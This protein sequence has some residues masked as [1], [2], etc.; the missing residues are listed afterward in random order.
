MSILRRFKTSFIIAKKKFQI[1]SIDVD[2]A[3]FERKAAAT[4]WNA[5]LP[6][7]RIRVVFL[8]MTPQVWPSSEPV[9]CLASRDNRFH[10]KV[11]VVESKNPADALASLR[12]SR[13]TLIKSGVPFASG[14]NFSLEAY[15]PHI[16]FYPLPY[17]SLYPDEFNT[18][19]ANACGARIAYIPYGLE[20][21]GGAYNARYQFD[22]VMLRNAWRIFARSKSQQDSFGRF[23]AAGNAHVVL[24]GHPRGNRS[25]DDSKELPAH[26]LE[27]ARQRK[28]VLWTPHFSVASRRKWSSFIGNYETII[29]EI[30]N[31]KNMFFV[32][33]PHPF[34]ER[35]L[36]EAEGWT[37]QSAQDLL[38]KIG[39]FENVY[40]DETGDYW[41]AFKS[42]DALM[43]DAG[44]FLVEYLLLDKP[45]CFLQGIDSIGLTEEA[46]AFSAFEDGSTKKDISDFL[47]MITQGKDK[48]S[49][50]RKLARKVYFGER[51]E[52]A[53]KLIL[54]ELAQ[55][56]SD[57]PFTR[58]DA[59]TTKMHEAALA[60]WKIAS[61]TFLAPKEYYD[62]QEK[63]LS[64]L[65]E[66]LQPKGQA[67]DI[68]CGN[69]R[70]TEYFA[71]YCDFVEGIDPNATLINEARENA[72]QK[73]IGNI[74]YRVE[75]L[76]KPALIST[77]DLVSC[78]GVLSGIIDNEKFLQA[79]HWIKAASK[80]GALLLLK[81]SLSTGTTQS[82]DSNGYIAVYRNKSQ[83]VDAFLSAGFDLQ[84]EITIAPPNDKGMTNKLFVLK[85]TDSRV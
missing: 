7:E 48:K 69:G 34:L 55:S 71:K 68:G 85:A 60:Y 25:S 42:S 52:P 12:I 27:S 5:V 33:R 63:I 3:Q 79:T 10:T 51:A 21:G 16:I 17:N 11:V 29:S 20:V 47:D 62:K 50:E 23:C 37:A 64:E 66:A 6:Q 39:S 41:P 76:E 19:A 73:T 1:K 28:I 38:D 54:E 77:Y 46:N 40:V 58:S 57:R 26:V 9:W 8:V 67:I 30:E 44:S 15:K 74:D 70:F 24:T 83:Y 81:E 65:L 84:D 14:S 2:Y 61:T 45:V 32:F 49:P 4:H 13:D 22:E 43:T 35:T 53:A 72:R 36:R 80:P 56:V 59:A 18:D 75:N 78:M 31:R 82:V